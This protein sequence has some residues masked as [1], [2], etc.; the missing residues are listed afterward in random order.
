MLH[1]ILEER[2]LAA[3]QKTGQEIATGLDHVAL[4][5]VLIASFTDDSAHQSGV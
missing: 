5:L 3:A 1:D 4:P 2:G